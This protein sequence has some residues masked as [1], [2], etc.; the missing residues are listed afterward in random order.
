MATATEMLTLV[1]DGVSR[2]DALIYGWEPA[3][4]QASKTKS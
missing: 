1:D 3:R 2:H 4:D